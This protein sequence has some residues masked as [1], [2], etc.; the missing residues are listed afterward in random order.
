M[1]TNSILA[2]SEQDVSSL[3]LIFSYVFCTP[4]SMDSVDSEAVALAWGLLRGTHIRF[5][6]WWPVHAL[7]YVLSYLSVFEFR[8]AECLY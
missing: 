7:A 3:D 8:S 5:K 4:V 2:F 6:P 1:F